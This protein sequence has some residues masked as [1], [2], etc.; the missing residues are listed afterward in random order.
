[1]SVLIEVVISE[2]ELVEQDGLLHPVITRRGGVG[3]DVQ[4]T[5]HMWLGFTWCSD[6]LFV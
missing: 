5:R 3:V 4:P 2:L 1:M 6:W